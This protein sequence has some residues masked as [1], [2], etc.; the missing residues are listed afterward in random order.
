MKV[1][2]QGGRAMY[3]I[4]EARVWG[5]RAAVLFLSLLLCA[6]LPARQDEKRKSVREEGSQVRQAP[7]SVLAVENLNR[8]AAGAAEISE[9][10]RRDAGLLVELKRWVAKEATDNGQIVEDGDL[11]DEAIFDRLQRDVAFRAVATRL[12]QRYGYLTPSVNPN[13]EF[14]KDQEL[15]R[16]ERARRLVQI[17]TQEDAEGLSRGKSNE[18]LERARACD[19]RRDSDCGEPQAPRMPLRRVAPGGEAPRPEG[20]PPASP[21][22]PPAGG[23][24]RT[25]QA[26]G[27]EAEP[28]LRGWLNGPPGLEMASSTGKRAPEMDGLA[29]LGGPMERSELYARESSARPDAGMERTVPANRVRTERRT[30]AELQPVAMVHQPNPYAD[31]PSLYDMYVQASARQRP[32]ERFGLEIFRTGTRETDAVP[33]DLP[34]GPDY[35]VGP[36]DGLAID[37]WGG[38]SQRLVRTVDREGRL[39]LPE[40]GPLL[41]SGRT[42]GEVQDAVQHALRSQFRDVSADVSLSRLRTIRVY[43]VGD[44]TE[45]GAYD[46]SSLSTPLNAL[47]AAGGVTERGSLRALKHYRGKQL[48][49]EVDAYDLLLHGVRGDAK[50]LENGDTLLVPPLGAQV[51]VEGMVRRPAVYELHG[52]KSLA[53]VLELAGGILPAAALRHIEVQ[54]LDAHEKRSMLSLDI[55]AG[56]NAEAIA[57]QLSSF[58][59]HDGDEVHIFPIAPYNADTIYLE[60]HVLRPGRY[61]YKAGMKLTDLVASYNDLLP[62]PAPHYA[63]IVRLNAPDN[64]PSVESFDLAAALANPAAAPKLEPRDTVRIFS[65]FDFEPAPAVWVGGEVRA[66]GPYRTSGQAHLRDA[67]YLAGGVTPDA[68]L[69]SAQLFRSLPDGTMKILSVNLSEALAGDP[70]QNILLQPRDRILVHRNAKRVDPPTVLIKGEVDKP[71]RYPWA[72]NMRVSDLIRSAGGVKRSAATE[73]V[74]LTRYPLSESGPVAGEHHAVNLAAALAGDT[75][76]DLPLRDGDVLSVPQIAG[77]NDVGATI[78]VR[79]E[80]RNPG[81]YGIRPGERLSSVLQRAGGLLPTAYPGATLFERIEVRQLQEKSRQELIQRLERE[82]ASAKSAVGASASEQ[83]ALQ[84]A[85]YQQRERAVEGVRSAPATGRLVVN[86]PN[87]LRALAKSSGDIEVRAGDSVEIPKRP[88]FVLV[89]GQVYNSNAITYQPHKNA[90]WFLRRAGGPTNMADRGAIFII[91]ANGSVESGHGSLWS[92]GV[93]SRPMGPGDT[94]V[95][96]EKAIGGGVVWKNTLAIAQIA[97]SGALTALL[98]MR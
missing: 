92:G 40:A 46:I 42:L 73:T 47:V 24:A 95:V 35:V 62:E 55:S 8:V 5:R 30:E 2:W 12:L 44:V 3:V 25:L 43:V 56:S 88:G 15:L 68:L 90:G 64:H 38:V 87:D 84:Q 36:G 59:V 98:A 21:E 23:T 4:R 77:W 50:R 34:V 97:Q 19:G 17:E 93:L 96:P 72:E 78:T 80:V 57:G 33:M 16:R 51:T 65:R 58:M 67:I 75:A 32:P 20:N 6:P 13:S 79:G 52:E 54:R 53:E 82:A 11:T 1:D 10:L 69:D 27:G 26:G 39:S 74:D 9:V 7:P 63:E 70:V 14:A 81:V 41:V 85:A 31:I 71:G 48:V 83:A 91:R 49:E 86:V 94:I 66:P 29:P 37:L 60:G 18:P 28:D 22:F 61:S 76:Q 89:V 45:P